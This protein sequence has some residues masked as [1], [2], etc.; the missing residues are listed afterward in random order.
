[1]PSGNLLPPMLILRKS[2]GLSDMKYYSY[3]RNTGKD[4][5]V[6]IRR[7]LTKPTQSLGHEVEF[8]DT[9]WLNKNNDF[10][11]KDYKRLR[12]EK[13]ARWRDQAI[14]YQGVVYLREVMRLPISDIAMQFNVT[15]SAIRQMTKRLTPPDD[16]LIP[17]VS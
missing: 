15:E 13:L 17:H 2:L 3:Y 6:G 9:I 5:G 1:M 10:L 11:F 16:F 12:G 4:S 8:T 14:R 7:R